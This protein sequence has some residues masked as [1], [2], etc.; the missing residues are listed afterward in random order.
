MRNLRQRHR[1]LRVW[2]SLPCTKWCPWTSI[3]YSTED[4]KQLLETARRK[5]QRLLWRVNNFIKETLDEDEDAEIYFEWPIPNFGWKQQPMIDLAAYLDKRF[6]PW[7]DCRID[8]CNYG[9][10]LMD[11]SSIRN[12]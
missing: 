6:I 1:P 5:E 9:V 8:G 4:R 11:A 2:F 3:N 10:L 12:G 7:L